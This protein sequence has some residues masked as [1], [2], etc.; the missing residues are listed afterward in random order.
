[1]GVRPIDV[2]MT[3]RIKVPAKTLEVD[4]AHFMSGL[5]HQL[6]RLEEY[7]RPLLVGLTVLLLA[8]AVVGG[9]FWMDRQ[10]SEKAQA[11]ERQAGAADV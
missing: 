2:A 10:A 6:Q 9:V 3:Y 5:E 11:L 4:E 1:M 8:A 7:R